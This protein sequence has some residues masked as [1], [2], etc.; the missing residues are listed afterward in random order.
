MNLLVNY[1]ICII[2]HRLGNEAGSEV[3]EAIPEENGIDSNSVKV[4]NF[5]QA[6]RKPRYT[7]MF[8]KFLFYYTCVRVMEC[9]LRKGIVLKT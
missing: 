9:P 6:Q 1:C 8:W 5:S 3:V 4:N 2:L 7:P